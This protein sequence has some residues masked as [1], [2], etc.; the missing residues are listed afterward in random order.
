MTIIHKQTNSVAFSPQANYA[1]WATATG[2]RILVPAFMHRGM[3][4]DQRG[5]TLTAVN[6][7]FLDLSR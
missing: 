5:G 6:L 4:R 1:D 2:R 3:S 7:G